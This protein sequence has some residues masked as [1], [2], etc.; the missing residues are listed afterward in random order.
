MR[1]ILYFLVISVFFI[2]TQKIN[3]QEK[4]YT[5][6][7][8]FDRSI[9]VINDARKEF[10]EK[11]PFIISSNLTHIKNDVKIKIQEKSNSLSNSEFLKVYED[12]ENNT[13]Y[14][15]LINELNANQIYNKYLQRLS[16]INSDF[17]NFYY[18]KG[19]TL[20]FKDY[21]QLPSIR[22][23]EE[24]TFYLEEAIVLEK[25]RVNRQNKDLSFTIGLSIVELIPGAAAV[26]KI[27]EGVKK[28]AQIAKNGQKIIQN[29]NFISKLTSQLLRDKERAKNLIRIIS[30][31]EKRAK[32]S[33]RIA[34]LGAIATLTDLGRNLAYINES[35]ATIEEKIN[36][37]SKGMTAVYLQNLR[38]YIRDNKELIPQK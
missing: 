22:L 10:H 21:Y 6:S 31:A 38:D 14:N 24:V 7:E 34:N 20:K 2:K 35:N 12:I 3:S 36:E 26:T 4:K 28:G 16:D 29:Q 33:A 27:L 8:Y 37:F 23:A 5:K 25:G 18:D 19:D 17:F 30:N 1:V 11:L 32:I 13:T 15:L 9:K